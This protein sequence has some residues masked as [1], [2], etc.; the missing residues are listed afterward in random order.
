MKTTREKLKYLQNDIYNHSDNDCFVEREQYLGQFT[1]PE[2]KPYDFQAKLFAGLLEY[3]STPVNENDIFV[4]RIVEGPQKEGMTWWNMLSYSLG[5]MT[6]DYNLLL[7]C[8]HKG[9]LETIE[10]NAE[11]I[12]TE[13][14]RQYAEN[15]KTVIFAVK[16]Y[17]QRYALEAKAAGN[18]RAYKALMKV[19]FEP[20]YDLY[21]ALQAI[22]LSHMIAGGYVGSRDYAFGYMDEYLYP[23]YQKEK[24]NGVSDEEI[25]ELFAAFFVK[26]NEI[27]GRCAHN[28]NVKLVPSWSSKQYLMIDGGRANRLSEIILEALKLNCLAQPELTVALAENSKEEFKNKVFEAMSVLTDKLQVYN[29][30]L[31]HNFLLNKG[32]PEE[33]AS[34]PA[35]SACCTF[36]LNHYNIREEY[37]MGIMFSFTNLYDYDYST[38][39]E[40]LNA[41][42]AFVADEA[43]RYVDQF[44]DANVAEKER[45]YVYDTLLLT[46]CNENCEYPPNGLERRIK[47]IFLP[48]LATLGDSLAV[49]DKFVFGEEK[50]MTYKEFVEMLKKDFE[51]YEDIHR[52]ILAMTKFGND[53]DVDKYTVEM[54]NLLIDAVES[55]KLLPNEIMIP[56]FYSLQYDNLCCEGVAATPDGRKSG[57]PYSENQSPTYGTDKNG[58]TALLNSEAKLPYERTAAGGLNLTFGKRVSADILKALVK[59]YF[60][61]GGLHIGISVIDR[62]VLLAA[63]KDPTNKKYRSLT[64][65]LY[66]FSEYFV[67]LPEWQQIAVLNRTAY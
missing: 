67:S 57:K 32:L 33:I 39:E 8:G 31:L 21:S 44:R 5:H 27:C 7:T 30:D 1:E 54:A 59:T 10:K 36:D 20:A 60:S 24:E 11:K 61:Q 34:R 52:E 29:Y 14:A 64:V 6:P 18:E 58:I 4:G 9:I 66:G 51:G 22:W 50:R 12:G 26:P 3:V 56:G 45:I 28:H 13:S 47:V 23:F 16:S 49:L 41:F 17:A 43:Q 65:R 19:P 48:G 40:F 35:F 62:D 15:A 55:A 63:M 25:I 46:G 37:Y 2:N 38:K 53:S 42:K